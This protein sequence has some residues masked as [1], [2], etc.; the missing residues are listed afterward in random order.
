VYSLLCACV[1]VSGLVRASTNAR[2]TAGRQH[3]SG[4]C[5]LQ[6]SLPMTSVLS[7]I[8][9]SDR[10]A[11]LTA[12]RRALLPCSRILSSCIVMVIVFLAVTLYRPIVCDA[13]LSITVYMALVVKCSMQTPSCIVTI[14]HAI[15]D[16]PS[17]TKKSITASFVI[18]LP[19]SCCM[20]IQR[21]LMLLQRLKQHEPIERIMACLREMTVLSRCHQEQQ[22]CK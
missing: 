18:M 9:C 22:H 7:F 16:N 17:Q 8:T 21:V 4:Q 15:N 2:V 14:T 3:Q 10:P 11:A 12:G 1:C 19:G 13:L 20:V 6:P 5:L